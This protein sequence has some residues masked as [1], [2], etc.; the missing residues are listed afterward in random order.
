MQKK[1]LTKFNVYDKSLKI[2]GVKGTYLNMIKAIYNKPT[3]NIVLSGEKQ[4]NV[5]H[6]Q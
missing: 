1:L 4:V 3:T 2:V 5:L 6:N